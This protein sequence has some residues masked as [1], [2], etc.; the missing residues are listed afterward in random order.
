MTYSSYPT[1]PVN[2]DVI[3]VEILSNI[4]KVYLNGSLIITW[5]ISNQYS[6]STTSVGLRSL[7]STNKFDNFVVSMPILSTNGLVGY[8][9]SKQGVVAQTSLGQIDFDTGISNYVRG[10]TYTFTV[11]SGSRSTFD[12]AGVQVGDYITNNAVLN[13]NFAT[14]EAING[15]NL[16][17]RCWKN[18]TDGSPSQWAGE[19]IV[20]N[21][22]SNLAPNTST[23]YRATICGGVANSNGMNFN[24]VNSIIQFPKIDELQTSNGDYTFELRM[25]LTT[26]SGQD[27]LVTTENRTIYFPT[28]TGHT[29][30]VYNATDTTR[31][32]ET[33]NGTL[34]N[35]N[36]YYISFTFNNTSKLGSLYVNGSLLSTITYP[37]GFGALLPS[38]EYLNIGSSATPLNGYV[39]NIRLY[40]RELTS[41]EVSQNY[42]VKTSIGLQSGGGV[43]DA[44]TFLLTGDSS[45]SPISNVLWSGLS[46]LSSDTTLTPI[47]SLLLDGGLLTVTGDTTLNSIGSLILNGLTTLTGDTVLTSDGTIISASVSVDLVAQTNLTP[48]GTAKYSGDSTISADSSVNPIPSILLNSD[49]SFSADSSLSSIPSIILNALSSISAD[50]ILTSDGSVATLSISVNL[51]ASGDLN[52]IGSVVI[53]GTSNLSATTN[54][55]ALAILSSDVVLVDIIH[56]KGQ[57]SLT[58]NLT[59]KKDSLVKLVG[60]REM[61]IHLKGGIQ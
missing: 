30:R 46:S 9:N 51:D 41:S 61:T 6:P 23:K 33:F 58:V 47:G 19:Y 37:A 26:Y 8:W 31:D 10:Q 4:A 22:W 25:K 49:S 56:L 1:T 27:V 15:Y 45:L 53:G 16:T 39:D 17:V 11:A 35:D 59:G 2:G 20:R 57:R 43:I 34:T 3:K 52:A 28:N 14:I 18:T 29:V 54:L 7:D 12:S 5:S 55:N 48:D 24:G 32:S 60:S 21:T 40:N 13:D 42:N 38:T 36:E 50:S 44:G